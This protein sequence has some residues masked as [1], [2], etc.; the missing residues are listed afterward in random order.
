MMGIPCELPS[1]IFGDNQYVLCNT[2]LPHSKLKKKTSS[3]AYHYVRERVAKSS[4]KTSYLNTDHNP[5]NILTNLLPGAEE[6]KIHICCSP[7]Y[8]RLNL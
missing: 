5:S 1:F 7:L 4:W 3:I 2:S 8:Y 6:N